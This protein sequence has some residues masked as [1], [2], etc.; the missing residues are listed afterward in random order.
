MIFAVL[1]LRR[2]EADEKL[3]RVRGAMR[4]EPRVLRD[5]G[6][7]VAVW[8]SEERAVL[9]EPMG[10]A[11]SGVF[12]GDL[13]R[14][15]AR[16]RFA[17][18]QLDGGELLL[19]RGRV[20]GRSLFW[21]REGSLVLASTRL[22]MLLRA[23]AT[24]PRPDAMRLAETIAFDLKA[25]PS[26]TSFEGVRRLTSGELLRF[27][28]GGALQVSFLPE[29]A[30]R[31][32]EAPPE[33][34][35]SALRDEVFQ[36]VRRAIDGLGRIAVLAGGGLDSSA[37]L[38]VVAALVRGGSA[39]EVTALALDFAGP[40]DDRPYMADMADALGITP[41]RVAPRAFA[42][43]VARSLIVDGQPYASAMGGWELGFLELA[44][45]RGADVLLGGLGG[46]EL[47]D[48]D[49]RCYALRALRGDVVHAVL[50]AARLRVTWESS[51]LARVRE[52]VVRPIVVHAAPGRLRRLA[53]R[54]RARSRRRLPWAGPVLREVLQREDV[55]APADFG[56]R[57][58]A[59]RFRRISDSKWALEISEGQCSLDAH[60]GMQT[61][62]PFHDEALVAFVS[63]LPPEALLDGGYLRG[64]FRRA[65]AGLLPDRVRLR[66]D[67]AGFEPALEEMH[68]GAGGR[69]AFAELST[70]RALEELGVVR[71]EA[72][73]AE[74]DAFVCGAIDSEGWGSIWPALSVEA[75]AEQ[76]LGEA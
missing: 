55:D 72:Y 13:R 12:E 11:S 2:E 28:P 14:S 51:R 35:A 46:D 31:P 60:V 70:M 63:R 1:A 25:R 30:L 8:P 18:V 21:A 5:G 40:G 69:G 57:T 45:E 41:V 50:S 44:K 20:G 58:P 3:E 38:A 39:K 27:A 26:A 33:E 24:R 15:V 16:G 65:F 75:F 36:A 43:Q 56:P 61:R 71:G 47:F 17:A 6:A 7:C 42:P 74:F 4:D 29:P 49:P 34:L 59:E 37:L 53:R 67:K 10:C 54:R 48:G 22:P 68:A 32:L 62:T 73:R 76:A 23:L 64:L 52:Y 19:A 66:T 9:D